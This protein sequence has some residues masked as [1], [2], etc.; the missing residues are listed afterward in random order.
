MGSNATKQSKTIPC[1]SNSNAPEISISSFICSSWGYS[2]KAKSVEDF[3]I[4]LSEFY[5]VKVEVEP[6][7]YTEFSL[8]L[9]SNGTQKLIFSNDSSK[10]ETAVIGNL[11]KK[12][13][14]PKIKEKIE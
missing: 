11:L 10:K 5:N 7:K 12:E 8:Y 2:S 13:L 4:Y 1:K 3:A 14:F 9:N 6:G